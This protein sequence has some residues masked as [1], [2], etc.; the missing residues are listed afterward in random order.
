MQ[1]ETFFFHEQLIRSPS[2]CVLS[3]DNNCKSRRFCSSCFSCRRHHHHLFIQ[4][5]FYGRLTEKIQEY[6]KEPNLYNHPWNDIESTFPVHALRGS[7][8][9]KRLQRKGLVNT[10][11][12]QKSAHSPIQ[13]SI[14]RMHIIIS[15]EGGA[16]VWPKV[17][18]W[19]ASMQCF[20]NSIIVWIQLKWDYKLSLKG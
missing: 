13:C 14:D 19:H 9:F 3:N 8:L 11:W 15:Q 7:F 4:I 1:P 2:L 18:T 12:C 10:W 5:S 16:I 17:F 6:P 20:H